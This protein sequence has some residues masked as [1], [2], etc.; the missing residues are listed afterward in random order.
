MT[1][2]HTHL[3][4]SSFDEDRA[5]VIQRALDAGVRQ[6]IL[7][8][9][10]AASH[11]KLLEVYRQYP[12]V[13]MPCMG[14]HPTAIENDYRKELAVAQTYLKETAVPWAAIGEIG[15]DYYWSTAF[16]AEQK[17][18]FE[19]QLR[20]SV[21]LDL[22]VI[23][24]CREAM[25]D[26]LEVLENLHLPLRGIFHAYSG[27]YESYLRI[28]TLGDFRLGIGGVVTYKKA[29]LSGMLARVP[30]EDLVLET[31]SPYLSPV[32]YRGKR[33]ESAHLPLIAQKLAEI[34]ACPVE[35]IIA[36]T[37]KTVAK[38]FRFELTNQ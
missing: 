34:Y 26:M 17:I 28:K 33:N 35:N 32:P 24:H 11:P 31:D 22:P 18:A 14:V 21:A 7:P 9:I 6:M 37:R 10:D 25:G 19:E 36:E 8:A 12:S 5:L 20:W 2:T 1:D 38:I 15:L 3:F 13:L 16:K 4:D 27:S 30:L 29:H 23:L